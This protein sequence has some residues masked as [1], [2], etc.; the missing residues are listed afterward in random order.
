MNFIKLYLISLP[1]FIVI[2]L[3]WVGVVA[4]NFYKE[5]IG[6]LMAPEIRW[7]AALV[8]YFIYLFG[9]VFF[10]VLPAIRK[11]S[12]TQAVVYGALFGFVCYSTYDLTNFATLINWPFKVVY[13]DI[14]WGA[15]ASGTVSIITYLIVKNFIKN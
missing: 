5:Q 10:A 14:I 11:S 1:V 6:H 3:L 12:L 2:D 13:C 8:F 15:F 9:L 4:V 7:E